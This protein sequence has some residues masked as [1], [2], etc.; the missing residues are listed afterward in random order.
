M[1]HDLQLDH[2]K[3]LFF[4]SDCHLGEP[5]YETSR[6]REQKVVSWLDEHMDVAGGFFLLG[7]IFDFWFEYHHVIP[8]GYV[9]LLGKLAEITDRGIPVFFFTGNHDMWLS[10]YFSQELN[11][12]VFKEPQS[13]KVNDT[14]IQVGHGDGLGPGQRPY[15]LLKAMFANPFC[16]WLFRWIH[17]NVGFAIANSW[18][19]Q[20]RTHNGVAQPFVSPDDEK[21]FQYCLDT[22]K[23]QHHDLYVFGHRHLALELPINPK[24]IYYNVGEW[25][26]GF[27]FGV[28]NGKDFALDSFD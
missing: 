12:A 24:S 19:R 15:K 13:F 16:Q 21:I 27:T 11:I 6:D 26:Q 3:K 4:A 1:T 17:P 10:D 7:D 25:I 5:D 23:E 22:E 14:F 18:S 9:R 28:Y 2:G 8:K 20:S